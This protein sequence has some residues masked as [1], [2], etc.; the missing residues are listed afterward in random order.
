MQ[1]FVPH[2]IEENQGQKNEFIE[3]Q[4]SISRPT[5]HRRKNLAQEEQDLDKIEEHVNAIPLLDS[6]REG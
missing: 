6:S 5:R 3:G 1:N 4:S 2:S